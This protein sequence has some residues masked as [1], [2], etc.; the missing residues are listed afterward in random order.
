MADLAWPYSSPADNADAWYRDVPEDCRKWPFRMGLRRG[1][2]F[3]S[4]QPRP[5]LDGVLRTLESIASIH[6]VGPTLLHH[7]IEHAHEQGDSWGAIAQALGVARQTAYERFRGPAPPAM[8][9]R[10][11]VASLL[12]ASTQTGRDLVFQTPLGYKNG[13][14]GW[15]D[16]RAA[17]RLRTYRRESLLSIWWPL[18][19]NR[20]DIA[21]LRRVL[22]SLD[23][24]T[25]WLAA[26][27]RARGATW[28]TLSGVFGIKRQAMHKRF[29]EPIAIILEEAAKTR[30]RRRK[31]MAERGFDPGPPQRPCLLLPQRDLCL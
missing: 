4:T 17:T 14:L 22:G 19:R 1:F 5:G 6:A 9:S 23:E 13:E 15:M 21:V 18:P 16:P 31:V 28:A 26:E 8:T 29:Q 25:A 30:E 7:W 27:A 2:R 12:W 11:M 24:E 3:E 20:G 10:I